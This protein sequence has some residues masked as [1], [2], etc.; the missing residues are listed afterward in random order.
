MVQNSVKKHY[1]NLLADNYSW[2]FGDFD[3][4]V[5]ANREWFQNYDIVPQTNGI[6][7]DFG[8]G[9][10]FQSLAFS[11]LNFDVTAV[12]FNQQLLD[13][14]K[15]HDQKNAIETI[16]CNLLEKAYYLSKAPIEVAVCM[17]D[18]L[19]HLPSIQAASDFFDIV[20]E[21]LINDGKLVLSFRDYSDE[22]TGIDRFIP[23]HQEEDKIMSVF[24]EYKPDHV[25]VHDLIYERNGNSWELT[26]SAYPKIRV[27][28]KSI[29]HLLKKKNFA[30]NNAVSQKGMVCLIATKQ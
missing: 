6:V 26:K 30:I 7:I 15:E 21:L 29:S 19:A 5:T 17:G 22:M 4:Q 24:L 10:G 9:S 28:N 14:L 20:Y 18:T 8:C 16:N 13:E 3:Q 1:E 27:T 23:V 12:D 25:L 11:S 2:M